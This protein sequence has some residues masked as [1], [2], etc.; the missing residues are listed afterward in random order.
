MFKIKVPASSANLGCGFD[1][2]GIAFEK[3]NTFT[4]KPNNTYKVGDGFLD[5]HRSENNMVIS[6]AKTALKIIGKNISGFEVSV[7]A[8][9]PLSRGL[10]SSATCIIAGVLAAFIL[11]DT[12]I[13]MKTVYQICADIETHADNVAAA[14]F[15]ALTVAY[16]NDAGWKYLKYMPDDQYR[17]CAFIPDFKL[18]TAKS[19][20]ALPA[21]LSYNDCVNNISRTA[22]MV[23]ALTKPCAEILSDASSDKM[24]QPY[25]IPLIEEYEI[26]YNFAVSHKAHT[27]FISGAGPSVMAII[28]YNDLNELIYEFENNKNSILKHKWTAMPLLIDKN[29]VQIIFEG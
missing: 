22:L 14:L 11:S 28:N 6:S 23:T 1:T 25:R 16:K 29:G 24:H 26:I 15:G 18:N 5:A 21:K 9:I 19:R 20:K 17:F 8:D 7:D 13:D 27:A 4:F 10:G 12:E 3:Y 2:L